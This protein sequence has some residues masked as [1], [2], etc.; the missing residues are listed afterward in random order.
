ME[1][2]L[3]EILSQFNYPI[4]RQGSMSDDES[5]PDTFFTFWNTNSVDHSHYDDNEYGVAWDFYVY[6]YSN[7]PSLTYSVLEDARKALKQAGWITSG[8]GF[9]AASDEE[10]HTGRGLEAYYL[11]TQKHQ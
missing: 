4:Y 1:D 6:V 10:T 9:D 8:R 11:E 7:D 2:N 3:I 5:Y